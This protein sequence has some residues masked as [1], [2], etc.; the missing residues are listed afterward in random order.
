MPCRRHLPRIEELED[1]TLPALALTAAAVSAG[2]GLTSFAYN[3]SVPF[4]IAFPKIGGSQYVLV[5]DVSGNA[6]LFPSIQDGQ[7]A[8]SAPIT[9]NYG[10][11]NAFGIAQYGQAYYMAQEGASAV[12]QINPD[13][14]Y[15]RKV[16]SVALATGMVAN[17]I[18]GHLY[19]SGGPGQSELLDVDPGSGTV[20][21]MASNLDRADGV[22][23]TSDGSIVY[24]AEENDIL[25]FDTSSHTKVFDSGQIPS[26]GVDG[27]A[28]GTGALAGFIFANTNAGQVWQINLATKNQTLIA[29]GGS[30]GDFCVP[31]PHDG[32]L[33]LTQSDSILRLHPPA[34]SLFG[35]EAPTITSADNATFTIGKRGSFTVMA[36][37]F[38]ATTFSEMGAL[39]AGITFS[40]TGILSGTPSPGTV[41]SYPIIIAATNGLPPD[42]TQTFTLTVN[43]APV[44]TSKDHATFAA[45]TPGS[46]TATAT[47]VPTVAFSE[48]GNLPAGV[49]LTS[50]GLL[51]G[52]PA[53]GSGG[54]Y[55]ITI[56]ATNGVTPEDT[57]AFTLTVNEA[58]AITSAAY[59]TFLV[60]SQGSFT[61][62]A[63]GFPA[64]TFSETGDLPSGVAFS[65]SGVLSGTPVKGSGGLYHITITASNGA[66]PD[67]AQTF[68]LTVNE[69]PYAPSFTSPD[70]TAFAV[71]RVGDFH[72]TAT[73]YPAPS[74]RVK[75]VLPKGVSFDG[76]SGILAGTPAQ[77]TTG[78]NYFFLVASN[79]TA[80]DATQTF[81]LKVVQAPLFTSPNSATFKTGVAGSTT[82]TALGYPI[83]TLGEVGALPPGVLFKP[84]P[85]GTARLS[86]TPGKSAGGRY[87]ITLKAINSV[88]SATQSFTLIVNQAPAITSVKNSTFVV[89]QSRNFTIVASGF[90]A[91]KI[92][93]SARPAWLTLTG[94]DDGT[95]TLAGT[96]PEGAGGNYAITLTASNGLSPAATQSFILTVNEGPSITTPDSALFTAGAPG[97]FIVKTRGFPRATVT[98][99]GKLPTGITFTAAAN[100]TATFSG[101]PGQGSGG[102]Y[103]ITL[104]ASNGLGSVT[105]TFT[106]QVNQAPVITSA[107]SAAFLIGRLGTF[108][109]VAKGIPAAAITASVLPAWLKLDDQHDGT[110][111]LS[112]TPTAA[113][114]IKITFTAING[115]GTRA[116][117]NFVLNVS[118]KST[119]TAVSPALGML[120]P[121]YD[122]ELLAL[123]LSKKKRT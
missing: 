123:A 96:P 29:S 62:T 27:L 35:Y 21:V 111:I 122:L 26:P 67:A 113:D 99:A 61:M 101:T 93:S 46:F 14:T 16:A 3:L 53:A 87:P 56:T 36:T 23:V 74:F 55:H 97:T 78:A 11:Y 47:G 85:N 37:G 32:T 80:P 2:Y 42:A 24:V 95:A 108:T 89:G 92:A 91:A 69:A 63:T 57:Q 121:G 60:G 25:G 84:G 12:V 30:R 118:P 54:I 22:A 71:G 41:G 90:P 28:L 50:A 4:G 107:K 70:S 120:V 15:I 34:G 112:G 81:T 33:L 103:A 7:D 94:H 1:R 52:T 104:K 72:V 76:A 88:D 68:T 9:Q 48:K 17:P 19:V 86:G 44:I 75:G 83:P 119:G 73:G 40:S 38:P 114:V 65:V 58:P 82:L 117:Q 79:G 59:A 20:S 45:G 43:Q 31:D 105:Q 110:A 106:L 6:R 49:N 51:S 13:G 5:T 39:P 102:R 109:V 116:T 115:V 77:G 18:N 100:G 10:G 66:S 64:A 98:E 8:K